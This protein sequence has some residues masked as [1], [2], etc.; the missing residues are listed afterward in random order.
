ARF[1]E[2]TSVPHGNV[3]KVLVLTSLAN[4]SFC[5]LFGGDLWALLVV[6]IATAVGYC[7]KIC[8]LRLGMDARGVFVLSAFCATVVGCSCYV[9]GLGGTPEVALGT[10]VLYL[11]PGIPFINS[12]SDLIYGHNLCFLSRLTN[13]CVLT[14]CLSAGFILGL[15][16]MRIGLL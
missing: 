3:W 5:Y 15:L 9:F 10:S 12:I 7:A 4:M 6:F 11:V 16:V 13:A 2:I 14:V 1:D 8:L